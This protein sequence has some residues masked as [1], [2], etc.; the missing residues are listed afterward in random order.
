MSVDLI[1][2]NADLRKLDEEGFVLEIR[3][4]LLLIHDIP[5]VRPNQ[6]LARGMFACTLSLDPEGN[7]VSPLPDH[8]TPSRQKPGRAER[9][10][11]R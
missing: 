10:A 1:S 4:G 2:R 11:A 5:Y 6:T 7:T 3:D 9:L 8:T